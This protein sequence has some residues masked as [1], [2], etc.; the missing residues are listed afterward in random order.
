MKMDEITKLVDKKAIKLIRFLYCDNGSII[1]GKAATNNTFLRASKTGIGLTCAQ[2]AFNLFDQ[3]QPVKGFEPVG[4]VRMIPDIDSLKIL[5]Y[6]DST[7]A[8]ICDQV[9]RD[10]K[11]S[12]ACQRSFLKKMIAVLESYNIKLQVAFENEFSLY[13]QSPEGADVP[14]DHSQCFSSIAMDRASSI[15]NY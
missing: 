7:A 9:T 8:A 13:R 4:E 3:L 10:G 14:L 15:R 11:P 1:R 12:P 6:A 2:Q 5:P